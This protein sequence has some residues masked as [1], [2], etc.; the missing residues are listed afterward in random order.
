M[1]IVI[2]KQAKKQLDEC[3]HYIFRKYLYWNNLLETYGLIETRK[4]KGFHDEPLKGHRTGQRSV[5]LSR[6][7]RIIY[8]ELDSKK[9]ELLEIIEVNKHEY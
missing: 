9:Y 4:I 3:P 8:I 6:S 2:S 1:K 7:Y 5:R